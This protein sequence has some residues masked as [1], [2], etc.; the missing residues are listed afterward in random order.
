MIRAGVVTLG[1]MLSCDS[2]VASGPHINYMVHCMGC[3]TS[4]GSGTS[5]NVPGLKNFM[6]KFLEVDGGREFLIRV[7][8]AAQ[9]LLSDSDLA[10]LTNWM[11]ISFSAEQ[12]P[13]SFAPYTA[14]EVAILRKNPLVNVSESRALLV[15]RMEEANLLD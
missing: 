11:L 7:P 6:G 12:L 10:L 2:A 5:E 4:D 13:D 9:S 15:Q 14:K 3:H 8:G 1:L